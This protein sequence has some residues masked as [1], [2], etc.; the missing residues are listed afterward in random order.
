MKTPKCS[1]CSH[2]YPHPTMRLGLLYTQYEG[3]LVGYWRD[4]RGAQLPISAYLC[5]SC[6]EIQLCAML[7]GGGA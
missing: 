5:P 1:T 3:H 7:P 4:E 6:G 2:H